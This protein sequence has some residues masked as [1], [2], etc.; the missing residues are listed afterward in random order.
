MDV[1]AGLLLAPRVSHQPGQE[2][3]EAVRDAAVAAVLDLRDVLELVGHRLDDGALA[4]H[5][6]VEERHQPVAHPALC[7]RRNDYSLWWRIPTFCLAHSFY[8]VLI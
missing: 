5:D 1:Q 6:L 7:A 2:V 3:D 8:F 4:Q